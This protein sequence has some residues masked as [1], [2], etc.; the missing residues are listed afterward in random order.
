MLEQLWPQ[1]GE[2]GEEGEKKIQKG[3]NNSRKTHAAG[4]RLKGDLLCNG[5]AI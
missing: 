2:E 5:K 3:E 1:G 4:K